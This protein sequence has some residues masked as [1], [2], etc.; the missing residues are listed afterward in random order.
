[1]AEAAIAQL[2]HN[3]HCGPENVALVQMPQHTYKKGQLWIMEHAL[4]RNLAGLGL[5]V[6][7][8]YHLQFAARLDPRDARPLA[9]PGRVLRPIGHEW[10]HWQSA[11]LLKM[12]RTAPAAQ[13]APAKM[14]QPEDLNPSAVPLCTDVDAVGPQGSHRWQQIGVDAA[15]KLLDGMVDDSFVKVP[16]PTSLLICDLSLQVG[17]LARAF[18]QKR[19][20]L[21]L[22]SFFFGATHDAV[23]LDWLQH[24]LRDTAV[25]EFLSGGLT[26]PGKKAPAMDLPP[27]LIHQ[28]P[29][30]PTFNICVLRGGRLCVPEAVVG[31]WA[32]SSQGPDFQAW[33]NKFHEE[34]GQPVEETPQ[35]NEKRGLEGAG[36][37]PFSPLQQCARWVLCQM[38]GAGASQ[39]C[40]H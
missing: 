40:G 21:N 20:S 15:L 11:G 22:A 39:T 7:Q 4:L 35:K 3:V 18:L 29:V 32:L 37:P 34:F 6:D 1:M 25:S 23:T 14:R 27:D 36:D 9:Y 13:L 19:K 5:D 28:M 12:G 33:L 2:A 16:E 31:R 38:P 30:A 26:I 24:D 8:Q 17:D 10:G